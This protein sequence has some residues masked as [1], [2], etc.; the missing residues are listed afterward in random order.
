MTTPIAEFCNWSR[1]L[2]E[3]VGSRARLF[4]GGVGGGEESG[5]IRTMHL[6]VLVQEFHGPIIDYNAPINRMPWGLD[7]QSR[8]VFTVYFA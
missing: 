7:S 6:F 1:L 2:V 8:F 3:L 5:H 4:V